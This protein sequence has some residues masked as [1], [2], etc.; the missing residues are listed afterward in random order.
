MPPVPPAIPALRVLLLVPALM[1]ML[2]GCGGGGGGDD[3]GGD[4]AATP[5][6]TATT[7]APTA[8]TTVAPQTPQTERE[9]VGDC[10]REL[11]YRLTG[12]APKT[13]DSE[14]ADYQI[15]LVGPP[16]SG[17]IGFYENAS[18]AQRVAKRLRR[19]LRRSSSGGSVERRGSINIAW[20]ALAGS[21]A[22][23]SVRGCLVT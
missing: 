17:Y 21:A 23:D 2:A 19:N 14:T 8:T 22:R 7:T 9:R 20:V 6:P 3:D 12:G 18:R 13:K 11:G 5:T 4:S 10:L 1:L 15:I 16:G